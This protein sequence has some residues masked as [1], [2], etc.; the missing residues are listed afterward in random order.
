MNRKWFFNDYNIHHIGQKF[1]SKRVYFSEEFMF[2]FILKRSFNFK[3]FEI[4]IYSS[5]NFVLFF[6]VLVYITNFLHRNKML[7]FV[8][9][10]KFWWWNY[11][12]CNFS[13]HTYKFLWRWNLGVFPY[14]NEEK[15]RFTVV[16]SNSFS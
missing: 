15:K 1:L 5:T 2:F 16:K 14:T 13:L 7:L 12:K 3:I 10:C 6:F 9:T 4:Y 11:T 8:N